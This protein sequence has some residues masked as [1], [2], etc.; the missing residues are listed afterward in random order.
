[1]KATFNLRTIPRF[2]SD[3]SLTKKASLNALGAMLDYG[4]R[5]VVGLVIN[6]FMVRGLGDYLYGVLQ[7]LGRLILYISAASGRPTQALKWTIANQQSSVDFEAKRRNVGSALTV[8]TMFIP[9]VGL[10]GLFLVWLA[11]AWLNA[12]KEVI[13]IIR[14]SA[15]IMSVDLILTTLADIPQSTLQGE[16]LGYKRMGISTLLVLIGGGGFTAVALYFKTGLIGVVA[17]DLAY[18]L[19]AG[20]FFVY[21]ARKS[22]PWFGVARPS[23]GEISKFFGL[24]WWFFIWRLVNQLM[25]SSDVIVLGWLISVEVVTTYTLTKYVP[26]TLISLVA[27]VATGITPGLGGLMGKGNLNKAVKVRNEMMAGTWLVATIV[28]VTTLLWNQ[29]F[30]KMWVGQERYSGNIATMLIMV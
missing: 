16:N 1:M 26:E 21:V 2:F 5:M 13:W 6:P 24:S 17:A 20:L 4:A 11:P 15:A 12:P 30:V 27:V 23:K 25:M 29:D 18:T 14:V 9:V 28:G 8:W 10:L 19:V 3:Q 7:I 22:I